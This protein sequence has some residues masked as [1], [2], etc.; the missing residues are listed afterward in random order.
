VK[1]KWSNV[2]IPEAY[3][4]GLVVGILLHLLLP[5]VIFSERWIGF[6]LGGLSAFAGAGIAVWAVLEASD[7]S[8]DSPDRLLVTG[9]YALSRNPMYVA[10]TVIGQII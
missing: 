5:Q 1:W 2:P 4:V 6:V 10:W 7:M 8:I 9:P 3:A